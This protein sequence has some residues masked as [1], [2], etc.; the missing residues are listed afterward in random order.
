[1]NYS[2]C[3]D[4]LIWLETEEK[5]SSTTSR[6]DKSWEREIRTEKSSFPCTHNWSSSESTNRS[7]DACHRY[8]SAR[9][10]APCWDDFW[11][12]LLG[13]RATIL[14]SNNIA[15][16]TFVNDTIMLVFIDRQRRSTQ[17]GATSSLNISKRQHHDI[18]RMPKMLS[19]RSALARVNFSN[20]KQIWKPRQEGKNQ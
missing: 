12:F 10:T 6:Y 14:T 2:G 3:H 16:K 20:K 11:S 4:V 7:D 17:L 5:G 8:T 9:L 15:T 18:T 1:M 19:I 13:Y